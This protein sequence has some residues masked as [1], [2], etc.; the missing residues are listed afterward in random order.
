MVDCSYCL[1]MSQGAVGGRDSSQGTVADRVRGLDQEPIGRA[2]AERDRPYRGTD[3]SRDMSQGGDTNEVMSYG[4][5]AEKLGFS[6]GGDA[7]DL[8][9]DGGGDAED[10]LA[11][12]GGDADDLGG[13]GGSVSQMLNA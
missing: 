2:V 4:G 7:E 12:G 1:E 6:Y 9:A 13:C 11:D 10:L 3:S 8:L 5:D